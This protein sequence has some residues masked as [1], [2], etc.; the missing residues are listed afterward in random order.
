MSIQNDYDAAI[1]IL[2]DT[3]TM[4]PQKWTAY[5]KLD[6][7]YFTHIDFYSE[8][9]QPGKISETGYRSES[10]VV[11]LKS[12][13]EAIDWIACL[14]NEEGITHFNIGGLQNEPTTPPYS[15]YIPITSE[16]TGA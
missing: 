14:L 15:T 6:W 13:E 1:D 16:L 4:F 11:K 7:I 12:I 2:L 3:N 9:R 5:I 10:S 8:G